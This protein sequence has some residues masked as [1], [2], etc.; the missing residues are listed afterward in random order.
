[1]CNCINTQ[2]LKLMATITLYAII[3]IPVLINTWSITLI[4]INFIR[5][6]IINNTLLLTCQGYYKW[7]TTFDINENT[8][9]T[10]SEMSRRNFRSSCTKMFVNY[11]LYVFRT[12]FVYFIS[13]AIRGP[14]SQRLIYSSINLPTL[15][16]TFSW[17]EWLVAIFER[18]L[19]T[20]SFVGHQ[21]SCPE[22]IQINWRD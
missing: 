4:L 17:L 5:S 6:Q 20:L 2:N 15:S 9:A 22:K 14:C 7:R 3:R 19:S 11:C 10:Y 12:R 21:N 18:C 8:L 13:L 16:S 1:M